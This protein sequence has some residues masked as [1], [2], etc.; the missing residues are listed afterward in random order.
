[1]VAAE[2][3]V[4]RFHLA[5][6]EAHVADDDVVRVDLRRRPADADAVAGGRLAGD[7]DEW[8]VDLERRLKR[9]QSGDAEDDRP[10]PGGVDGGPQAAGA[11]VLQ[12]RDLEHLPAAAAGRVHA[13][14]LRPRTG[15]NR[16][17]PAD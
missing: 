4:A 2:G 1:W 7:G 16:R 3:V 12:R 8:L 14:A 5:A 6:A 10:R 15:R 17:L 13:P 11:V 9:D